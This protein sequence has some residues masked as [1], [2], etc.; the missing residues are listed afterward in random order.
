MK[1]KGNVKSSTFQIDYKKGTVK[2]KGDVFSK[3][4]MSLKEFAIT[5]LQIEPISTEV[6]AVY[7]GKLGFDVYNSKGS[8]NIV[9]NKKK[10]NGI[11]GK[12]EVNEKSN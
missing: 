9:F 10:R 8:F 7:I 4:K 6:I 5:V 12:I 11:K 1:C 3:N 2:F